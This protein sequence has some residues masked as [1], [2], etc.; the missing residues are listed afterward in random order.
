MRLKHVLK[1]CGTAAAIGVLAAG[2]ATPVPWGQIYTE[3]KF[4]VAATNSGVKSTKV[5]V[6][7]S[8]SILGLVALGDASIETAA[9]N[10]GISRISHVDYEARN[11]LG[12]IGEYTTT[13]YGE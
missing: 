2:C 4:P 1:A 7:K 12:V 8:Q 3:V 10:G 13:V 11:I 5:G 9:R 6:A